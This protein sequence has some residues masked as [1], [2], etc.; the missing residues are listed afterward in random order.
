MSISS[1]KYHQLAESVE[2][3]LESAGDEKTKRELRKVCGQLYFYSGL[4]AIEF[5]LSKSGISLYSIASHKE[6]KDLIQRN[7]TLFKKP[8]EVLQKYSILVDYDYRRKVAYKGEDG[9]KFIVIKEFAQLC[10]EELE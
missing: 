7:Y 3:E 4:S 9:N 8:N 6:R 5:V 2:K 10:Q 1:R